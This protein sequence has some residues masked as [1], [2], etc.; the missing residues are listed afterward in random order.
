MAAPPSTPKRN[1]QL[2]FYND[3]PLVNVQAQTINCD[4]SLDSRRRTLVKDLKETVN[5]VPLDFFTNGLLPTIPKKFFDKTWDNLKAS[6]KLRFGRGGRSPNWS[7]F[8]TAPSQ[9]KNKEDTVFQQMEDVIGD[10]AEAAGL[11]KMATLKFICR[12]TSTP[13][14]S[15]RDNPSKPDSYG[16][17]SNAP[18]DDGVNWIDIAVPGEFKKKGERRTNND[19]SVFNE[20]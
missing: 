10:I 9:R 5:Q 6:K 7:S 20:L 1:V 16:I 17:L 3:S 14:S 19:V 2:P 8:V 18:S 15:T 12:P 4:A 13:R 11:E